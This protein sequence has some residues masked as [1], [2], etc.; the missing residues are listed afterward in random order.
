MFLFDQN[1]LNLF[2][3][4]GQMVAILHF[5]HNVMSIYSTFWSYHYVG[6][7]QK[8]YVD[9]KISYLLYFYYVQNYINL[10]FDFVQM[11]VILDFSSKP[12][13]RR[14]YVPNFMFLSQIKIWFWLLSPLWP[15]CLRHVEGYSDDC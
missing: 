2:L 9:A 7:G 13:I 12:I 15:V 1:E 6:H 11:R 8:P 10:L 3:D 4:L 14:M 5:P